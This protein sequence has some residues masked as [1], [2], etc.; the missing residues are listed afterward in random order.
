[1]TFS[2]LRTRIHKRR[3]RRQG[4]AYVLVLGSAMLVTIIGL[5]S[6]MA[7][8]VQHRSADSS[9]D[10]ALARNYA[11]S[12]IELATLEIY[13]DISW[14][15]NI[16]HDTWSTS[17]VIGRGGCSWKLVDEVNN[18]LKAD[19]NATVRVFGKGVAGDSTWIYSVLVQP[20]LEEIPTNL[21]SNGDFEDGISDWHDWN[22]NIEESDITHNGMK[23]IL[24]DNR[25]SIDATCYQYIDGFIENGTTYDV[26]V[27][28]RMQS[29]ATDL[30]TIS[31]KL[32][33]TDGTK[34]V[35]TTSTQVGTDWTKI[36]GTLTPTWTGTL[37]QVRWRVFTYPDGDESNFYI[38]DAV[39]RRHLSG[40]GYVPG[41]WRRDTE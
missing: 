24:I 36:S 3:T 31:L 9:N 39:M 15:D 20:P 21:L 40:P 26:E 34:M 18:S 28:A 32:V 8:R 41:T 22:C 6:M 38:D 35:N 33:T 13:N 17:K 10:V 23:S 37:T 1:M 12:A 7:M 5:S 14:R 19:R 29:T 11:Q 2:Y 4:T 25:N 16:A 30:V 27:W